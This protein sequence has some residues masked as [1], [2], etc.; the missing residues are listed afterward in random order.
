MRLC[1]L[2]E[3]IL[4]IAILMVFISV[5]RVYGIRSDFINYEAALY[6]SFDEI[7]S[8]FY[9]IK[10]PGLW[11]LQK[12]LFE[13]LGSPVLAWLAI[14]LSLVCLC[15]IAAIKRKVNTIYVFV[16]FFSFYSFLGMFNTYRQFIALTLV[17]WCGLIFNVRLIIIPSMSFH[18]VSAV[19]LLLKLNIWKLLLIILLFAF[20]FSA[21][22]FYHELFVDRATVESGSVLVYVYFIMISF[23]FYYATL[24]TK[25]LAY[26]VIW[27]ILVSSLFFLNSSQVE[28]IFLAMFQLSIPLSITEG[29]CNRLFMKIYFSFTVLLGFFHPSV[30]KIL[31]LID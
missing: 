23:Y 9:Y 11:F 26:A 2:I 17:G 5:V 28:R 10:E 7:A 14:D 13:L 22:F 6:L 12:S 19:A 27:L 31:G 1:K 24:S 16:Y 30:L 3:A 25:K 8:S 18:W 29:F 4:T 20:V 15:I 21:P